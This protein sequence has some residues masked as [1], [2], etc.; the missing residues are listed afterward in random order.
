MSTTRSDLSTLDLVQNYEKES[1]PIKI[2]TLYRYAGKRDKVLIAVGIITAFM[3]GIM[4]PLLTIVF[5]KILDG[6]NDYQVRCHLS[7]TYVQYCTLFQP[8]NNISLSYPNSTT[9]ADAQDN[10]TKNPVD[11]EELFYEFRRLTF[12]ASGIIMVMGGVYFFTVAAYVWAFSYVA[13]RQS[14]RIRQEFAKAILRKKMSWIDCSS[15]SSGSL[16]TSLLSDLVKIETGIG[17]PIGNII[18]NLTVIICTIMISLYLNW[19]LTLILLSLTPLIIASIGL[20]QFTSSYYSGKES[21]IKS[22]LGSICQECFSMIKTVTAFNGQKAEI[23]RFNNQLSGIKDSLVKAGFFL[24]LGTGLFHL[25]TNATYALGIYVGTKFMNEET[26]HTSSSGNILVV[27]WNVAIISLMIVTLMP[28]LEMFQEAFTGA[29]PIFNVIDQDDQ[30]ENNSKIKLKSQIS[31]IVIRNVTFAYPSRPDVTVLRDVSLST[32]LGETIAFVGPSGSGKSCLL[33][34]L[35]QFYEANEGQILVS[36][37]DIKSLDSKS[38]RNQISV[39][40]QEPVLFEGTV[41][42]NILMGRVSDSSYS[43]NVMEEVIDAAK[44]ANAHEFITKLP[45]QY[46]TFLTDK[47]QLSGGQ[48]QRVAIARAHMKHASVFLLDEATSA[49]DPESQSIVQSALDSEIKNNRNRITIIVAHKLSEIKDVDKIFVF[50]YGS[51]IESGTH[52]E[53][54]KRNG[55]YAEMY[56]IQEVETVDNGNTILRKQAE[57]VTDYF[58]SK[59]RRSYRSFREVRRN[60]TDVITPVK[61]S[62]EIS[63][64]VFIQL[65]R[66]LM[67]SKLTLIFGI[68][69]AVISGFW[70]LFYAVL[71]GDFTSVLKLSDQEKL[72]AVIQLSIKFLIAG[73]IINVAFLLSGYLFGKLSSNV[74]YDLRL[75]AFKS[76][77]DKPIPWFEESENN[78]GSIIMKI[79]SNVDTVTDY[80]F[81]R[82]PTSIHNV[83]ALTACFGLALYQSWKLTIVVTVFVPVI[84][85]LAFLESAT[86]SSDSSSSTKIL[87]LE[88]MAKLTIQIVEAF[89]TITSF[90]LQNHFVSKY[91]RLL[92]SINDTN[93]SHAR[94]RAFIVAA[95]KAALPVIFSV[96]FFVGSHWISTG[97]LRYEQFLKITEGILLAVFTAGD[98]IRSFGECYYINKNKFNI[99]FIIQNYGV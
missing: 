83:A 61:V 38:L 28:N 36:G 84:V 30:D 76:I 55:H 88:D 89:K 19:K 29:K 64:G 7:L 43:A 87:V 86:E 97:E 75:A 58:G 50:K 25:F 14:F 93:I 46:Q 41:A 39:V 77:I 54:I 68:I 69:S 66:I 2:S 32:N 82:F 94:K 96:T 92:R 80:F 72:S 10:N 35:Q 95:S 23:T 90:N 21:E 53:L 1:T 31:S 17:E 48:K 63:Q 62:N 51:I 57:I 16:A 15:S 44:R 99:S 98:S 91:D 18:N 12:T 65:F 52:E 81:E 27:F 6:F 22:T 49:L 40:G 26:V 37:Q 70:I 45:N 9:V 73:A 34:L 24:G 5:A 8:G 4:F 74:S 13:L 47:S 85:L 11:N 60:S 33:E 42:D 78:V 3:S 67:K 59:L 56:K 79:I 20:V 71:I